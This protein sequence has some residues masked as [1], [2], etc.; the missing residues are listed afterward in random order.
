VRR[1]F[2]ED[3]FDAYR[4]SVQDLSAQAKALN[5]LRGVAFE[6]ANE[7]TIAAQI[8]CDNARATLLKD[9]AKAEPQVGSAAFRPAGAMLLAQQ[10]MGARQEQEM[11]TTCILM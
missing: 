3:R 4:A 11:P 9:S 5:N 2:K 7:K 8:A 6:E 10:A 1:W